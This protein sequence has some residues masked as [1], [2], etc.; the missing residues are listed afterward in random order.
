MPKKRCLINHEKG[1]HMSEMKRY[2]TMMVLLHWVLAIFILG[3]IFVGAFI[4]D[5]ME[6]TN[7]QKITLLQI[8]MFVG[9]SI[10]LLTVFRLI[11]RMRTQQP[12]PASSHNKLIDMIAKGMHHLL[13]LLT[14][15]T[16]L[17]GVALAYSADLSAIVFKHTG[18]LPKDF[19]DYSAHEIHGIFAQLLLLTIALHVAAALYHQFILKDGLL[20]RMTFHKDK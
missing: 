5:E 4:L 9:V 7:P 1:A 10:L 18:A 13:Y 11:V 14:L 15:L 12:L 20:S 17:A 19:E 16:A 8:H 2:S 3:A 6:S